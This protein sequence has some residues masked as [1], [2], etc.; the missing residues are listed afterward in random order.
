MTIGVMAMAGLPLPAGSD[1]HPASRIPTGLQDGILLVVVC[2]ECKEIHGPV[3]LT[4]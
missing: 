2:R 1:L 4:R 3:G